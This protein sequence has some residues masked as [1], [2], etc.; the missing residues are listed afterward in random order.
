[1]DRR[2]VKKPV[3][4]NRCRK[5]GAYF[6]VEASFLVPMAVFIMAFLIYCAFLLYG[7]CIMAQDAYT[8]AQRA[9]RQNGLNDPTGYVQEQANELFGSRYFGNSLPLVEAWKSGNYI[10]VR[11]KCDTEHRV[12]GISDIVPGKGWSSAFETKAEVTD[13]PSRIR[14]MQRISDIAAGAL[15]RR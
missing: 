12:M 5:L 11:L 15:S 7:R 2:C 14:R 8:L 10:H 1:M 4:P 13:P 9:S 6:T 3:S